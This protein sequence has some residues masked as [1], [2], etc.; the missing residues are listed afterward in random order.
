MKRAII[1]I[2]FLITNNVFAAAL[3][4][5]SQWLPGATCWTDNSDYV[6]F[7]C[8][9]ME[10]MGEDTLAMKDS[11]QKQC[12]KNSV[13]ITGTDGFTSKC[14][15]G[16]TEQVFTYYEFRGTGTSEELSQQTVAYICGPANAPATEVCDCS[17]KI[18]S[19]T[20]QSDNKTYK[21]TTTPVKTPLTMDASYCDDTQDPD[22]GETLQD[23]GGTTYG[24]SRYTMGY[25]PSYQTTTKYACVNNYYLSGTKCTACPEYISHGTI[26]NGRTPDKNTDDITSCYVP[27]DTPF[28]DDTGEGIYTGNTYWLPDGE[29]CK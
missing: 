23:C 9:C 15:V 10:T 24:G 26:M 11:P 1:V 6:L 22:T 3:R 25:A 29:I 27:K 19:Y 13:N 17:D 5:E 12:D 20:L 28:V 2:L 7:H 21:A 16:T 8:N 14:W 18:I 4:P